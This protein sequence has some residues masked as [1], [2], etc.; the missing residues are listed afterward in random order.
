MLR[1]S[2]IRIR[3]KLLFLFLQTGLFP[4]VVA[5]YLY[6]YWTE[7]ALV[8]ESFG[9]LTTVQAIRKGQIENHFSRNFSDIRLLADSER[10]Y[11]FLGRM[12]SYKINMAASSLQSFNVATEEYE[13]LTREMRK[14]LQ[15]YAFLNGYTDLYLIDVEHGQVM[16]SVR[17]R[18]DNGTNLQH[19]SLKNSGLAQ[20][21]REVMDSGTTVISDFAPYGPA[22]NRE[23][24]FI[25]H[26]VTNLSGQKISVVVLSFSPALISTITE[27]RKGMGETG[28]SYLIGWYKEKDTFEFRSNM[29]TMGDGQYVVGYDLGRKLDYWDD[30]K[31]SGYSGARGEYIDSA[32]RKVL[33]A[34]DKLK[35]EGLD[36]YLISKIDRYEVTAPVRLLYQKIG[37]FA[38]FFTLLTAAWAWLLSRGFTRPILRDIEFAEQISHGKYDERLVDDRKD[39][40]GDL[41]RSLNEMAVNLKEVNWLKSGKEQLDDT[42]RGEL[43]PDQLARRCISF[44][45]KYFEAEL[46]AIFLNN[47]GTL[48]L[49]A[50]H[51]FSDRHGNFNSFSFGEGLV[52]QAALEAE[53]LYFSAVGEDAPPLNYGAGQQPL[54][55]YLCAPIHNNGDVAGV[56]LIGTTT[57]FT[58]LQKKFLQQNIA[59][60]AILFNAAASRQK[61]AELLA[62]ARLQQEKLKATNDQLEKQA[63]TLRQSQAEMQAQQE[64]LRVTNEELEEQARALQESKAELQAQQEEL[65]V[66]NEELEERTRALEEQKSE[67]W[68]TNSDLR[69][70]QEIV[71]RKVEEL[72]VASK[73]KSEF[74][75]NMSH[76]L[77]TPLNSI[78]IL[79]QLLGNNKDG[80]LNPRQVESAQAINSSGSELLKLINE[81]LD[82]SKIEA[83]KIDLVI[84]DVPVLR[85]TEDL[86]RMYREVAKNKGLNLEFVVAEGLPAIIRTD[87]QRLQQILR[88][89]ITNAFKFTR[90]GTVSLHIGRPEQQHL[91]DSSLT[92]DNS[93]AFAVRDEGIGIP[94]EKQRVIFEAFQQADGSTSRNYGG[95]G[96]GLSI[97]K[98]LSR[99]LGGSIHLVS[100]QGKGSTFTVVVPVQFSGEGGRQ[101]P[102]KKERK[103]E[104]NRSASTEIPVEQAQNGVA[105]PP[106]P[107]GRPEEV[108]DDRKDVTPGSK[109]LLIIEDDNK[110]A[111]ILRDFARE[112]GF[113][114]VIAEDGET[115]LHFAD[116]YRPSAIIL[117]IGLPGIDGWNVMERLKD[118]PDLR[119]IPVHFMSAADSSLDALRMG[120]I[121]Y[122]TKPVSVEKIDETFRKLE[123]MIAKPVSRLLLVE[124]DAIQRESIKELIGNSDV[125]TTAVATGAEAYRE[126]EKGSYDCVILDLGLQDMSGFELLEKVRE[127]GGMAAVPIIIYTGREL[128]ADEEKQLS[129]YAE[130]I[131]IKGV[132]SPERLLD[133]SALFL[134]RVEADLPE[135]KRKMLKMVHNQEAV[136]SGSKILLVDDDMRNVFALSS[137]LEERNIEIVIARD[138]MECLEKLEETEGIDAVLMDIMMPRMDGYEAMRRIRRMDKFKKLPIIAL[139]A[140]AM[141]GD[142]SKCIEAGANDY[143]AKPVNPDKLLS[144]LRVWLY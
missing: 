18:E 68:A 37:W 15:D 85:I 98:E 82:L 32:G 123:N 84:E 128:T 4:I 104:K 81:I 116:Y 30:A 114:C 86:E 1:L 132:K 99:L 127:N 87:S 55:Q 79:S 44:F 63:E 43:E 50:S 40:L 92:A 52:G 47:Q 97:S 14:P 107:G 108:I 130:S 129:R 94:E 36:W 9:K 56:M 70:A 111:T 7:K 54:A 76:E 136:L 2:D 110:F 45:V 96:L 75:A 22:E 119:H 41:A 125:K 21:W 24:A 103:E 135:E 140:K 8:E 48:E 72:E 58:G 126:L 20:V 139:T 133:E 102:V 78:L 112:R 77:R 60:M 23:V 90:E 67:I 101:Q 6:S 141:K 65:R 59:N 134:H 49:R 121:G 13:L 53:N 137:V 34:F 105:G 80:N 93:L 11:N 91:L 33:V 51:S 118:N 10:I 73:Y 38:V 124:D 113:Q 16:F 12:S 89:L 131:I 109:S 88:N 5:G 100:V 3:P 46:G 95:T 27:S 138:G 64:E 66:T 122:L 115:G 83:G 26:P 42:I 142:R 29:T 35:I 74:L 71:E 144:M 117:D 143:L 120:A 39:E 17:N 57:P 69:E 19:G 61:I 25:G 106:P 31:R 62:A 28:E